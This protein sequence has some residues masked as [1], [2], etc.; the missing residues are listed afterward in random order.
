LG[1]KII[2]ILVAIYVF[3]F[4]LLVCVVYWYGVRPYGD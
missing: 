2:P 1:V 4:F 3:A